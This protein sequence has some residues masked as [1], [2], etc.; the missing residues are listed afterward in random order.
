[1]NL[2]E[3]LILALILVSFLMGWFIHILYISEVKFKQHNLLDECFKQYRIK[4]TDK[5]DELFNS[6][7]KDIDNI[8]KVFCIY[9][10]LI[11]I[12]ACFILVSAIPQVT[13]VPIPKVSAISAFTIL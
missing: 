10:A 11:T 2:N 13:F 9:T 3:I 4:L 7:N 6:D 12:F 5:L 8:S 1:M